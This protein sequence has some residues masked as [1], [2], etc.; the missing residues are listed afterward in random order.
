[1]LRVA[2]VRVNL[3]IICYWDHGLLLD[4]DQL[5]FASQSDVD[6][7][8]AGWSCHGRVAAEGQSGQEGRVSQE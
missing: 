2:D 7:T 3:I 6:G 8:M 4:P 5:P 1:M